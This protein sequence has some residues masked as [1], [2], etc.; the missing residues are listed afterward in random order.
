MAK[1]HKMFILKRMTQIAY[2]Q[3]KCLHVIQ[4]KNMYLKIAH[5]QMN[6][7][8]KINNKINPNCL[9][10]NYIQLNKD[11]YLRSQMRTN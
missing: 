2:N 3:N 8:R 1:K 10:R 5:L 11:T 7:M 9:I 6:Q 4:F